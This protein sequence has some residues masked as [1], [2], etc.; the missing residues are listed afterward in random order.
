MISKTTTIKLAAM[1]ICCYGFPALGDCIRSCDGKLYVK[2]SYQPTG[3]ANTVRKTNALYTGI[4]ETREGRSGRSCATPRGLRDSKD[5]A[6]TEAVRAVAGRYSPQRRQMEAICGAAQQAQLRIPDADWYSIDEIYAY[7]KRDII[8]RKAD[9]QPNRVHFSCNGSTPVVYNPQHTQ[10]AQQSAITSEGAAPPPPPTLRT[11][12]SGS[13]DP[14]PP[15]PPTLRTGESSGG[16][17]DLYISEF[18]LTPA[19]PVKGQPV[20]V[21]VGVYN[22][23][24][25]QAGAFTVKWW[26]GEN[27]PNPACSWN[28]NKMNARG[29]RILNC[30]YS[31][32]PSWYARINTK[33][34]ADTS[35]RVVESNEG[36][37]TF[38]KQISVGR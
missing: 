32:F 27:Y 31:G 12:E 11:G 26:P 20:N 1:L 4:Y 3:Q 35:N 28:I 30:T 19:T 15:P 6:C 18:Q 17:P 16:K 33:V 9:I 5:R 10:P 24:A 13:R 2:L 38:K 22:K 8:R 7:G 21:R 23:G 29:G 36:N 34:V 25:A 37:N 14:A